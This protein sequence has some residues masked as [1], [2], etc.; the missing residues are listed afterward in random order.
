MALH[1]PMAQQAHCVGAVYLGGPKWGTPAPPAPAYGSINFVSRKSKLVCRWGCCFDIKAIKTKTKTIKLAYITT[2]GTA[3]WMGRVHFQK[4]YQRWDQNEGRSSK[5]GQN[6][7]PSRTS[8]SAVRS[9]LELVLELL[10]TGHGTGFEVQIK[11]HF[12]LALEQL[13]SLQ[14]VVKT[15]H[16]EP[17]SGVVGR[18]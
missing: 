6:Q 1:A 17:K 9:L 5:P 16:L 18:R 8:G 10:R 3:N 15:L 11:S 7:Y 14:P 2:S 4:L 12:E 13:R